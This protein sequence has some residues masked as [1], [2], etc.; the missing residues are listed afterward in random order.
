MSVDLI[1]AAKSQLCFLRAGHCVLGYTEAPLCL[2]PLRRI[3]VC[4]GHRIGVA[5]SWSRAGAALRIYMVWTQGEFWRITSG[6]RGLP[7][8][9]TENVHL[10]RWWLLPERGLVVGASLLDRRLRGGGLQVV[11]PIQFFSFIPFKPWWAPLRFR[12]YVS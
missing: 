5:N 1:T 9:P 2:S 6:F 7:S 3:R 12:K 11:G 8:G 4:R 10:G